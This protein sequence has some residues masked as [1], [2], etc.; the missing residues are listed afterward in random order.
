M[1]ETEGAQGPP[2]VDRVTAAIGDAM[3]SRDRSRLIAL[4]MLKTAL[5]N[6]EVEKGRPLEA[7]ESLQVVAALVKQR[8]DAIDLFVKGGRRDLAEE[9]A[10]EITVL[11]AYLPPPV[12]E[13]ALTQAIDRAISDVGASSV[14]DLGRVMKVIMEGL[15]GRP[16]DGRLVS[17]MV[18]RKL[19]G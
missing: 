17:D 12:S 19:A 10:A 16:V 6:R 11:E 14:K 7:A 8:R 3:K 1:T 18:R 9:E 4:R 15:A 2:L 13:E 5:T